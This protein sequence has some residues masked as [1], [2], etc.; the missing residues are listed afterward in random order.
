MGKNC[1]VCARQGDDD[2]DA[3]GVKDH[4]QSCAQYNSYVWQLSTTGHDKLPCNCK[5][6]AVTSINYLNLLLK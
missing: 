2:D 5:S 3:F 1:I 6:I 4:S